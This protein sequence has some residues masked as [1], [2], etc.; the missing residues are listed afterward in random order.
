MLLFL[1]LNLNSKNN[2]DGYKDPIWADASG[3]YVYLPATFI[4]GWEPGAIPQD[5]P[6]KLGDGFS[7]DSTGK[8]QTKYPIGVSMME[9]PFFL[10]AHTWAKANDHADGYS[11]EYHYGLWLAGLFYLLL[12]LYFLRLYLIKRFELKVVFLTLLFIFLGTNLYYYSL[13]SSGMSHVYSFFLFAVLL[14]LSE[15]IETKVKMKHV[16]SFSFFAGLAIMVRPT[17]VIYILFLFFLHSG[18][19]NGLLSKFKKPLVFI[20]SVGLVAITWV[21]QM[22]YWNYSS[23]SLIQYSYGDEGF[24]WL[25]PQIL[26]FWFSTKNGL[27]SFAPILIFALFGIIILWKKKRAE[28]LKFTILFVIISYV[29]SAWWCWWYGCSF[30][31][32]SMVEFLVPLSVPFCLFIEQTCKAKRTSV[33][34]IL[35]AISGIFIFINLKMIYMYDDCFH[36]GVWDWDIFYKLI[37]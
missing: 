9:S 23:D 36:G 16:L 14:W 22:L 15:K 20:G 7:L 25:N 8:V 18:L 10:L 24:N 6:E 26:E 37:F 34:Y 13:N 32:R 5:W 3:Y 17:S 21:P 35:I 1:S 29:F 33:K 28:G 12:G 30:G 11:Y 19:I 2:Q 27:F 4:Y 31:S